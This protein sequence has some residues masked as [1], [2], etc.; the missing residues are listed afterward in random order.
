MRSESLDQLSVRH[1]AFVTAAKNMPHPRND[2]RRW[3][4][5]W[6]EINRL[7]EEINRLVALLPRPR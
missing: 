1:A 5:D 6:A 7:V 3:R 2:Y 4:R